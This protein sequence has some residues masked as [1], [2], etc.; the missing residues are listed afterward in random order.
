MV[1]C[2]REAAYAAFIAKVNFEKENDSFF[3]KVSCEILIHASCY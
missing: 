2:L 3:P 1:A